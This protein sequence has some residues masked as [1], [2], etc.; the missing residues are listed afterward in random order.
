MFPALPRLCRLTKKPLIGFGRIDIILPLGI[1]SAAAPTC[2]VIGR[3]RRTKAVMHVF[4]RSASLDFELSLAGP[5]F[6]LTDPKE[7]CANNVVV[8]EPV[9]QVHGPR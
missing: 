7:R 8:L 2:F 4:E 1:A 6:S 3:G 5:L 9:E